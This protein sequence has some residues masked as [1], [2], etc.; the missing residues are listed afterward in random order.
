MI[1]LE[2]QLHE[3][4]KTPLG[5][6]QRHH[7]TPFE[8]MDNCSTHDDK[9]VTTDVVVIVNDPAQRECYCSTMR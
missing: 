7:N 4:N 3:N 2:F 5:D 9:E 1:S 6:M 8:D